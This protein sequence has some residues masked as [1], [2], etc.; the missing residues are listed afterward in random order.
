MNDLIY[1]VDCT[2][3]RFARRLRYKILFIII[4]T[5]QNKIVYSTRFVTRRAILLILPGQYY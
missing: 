5:N 2:T 1:Y 4:H 3:V